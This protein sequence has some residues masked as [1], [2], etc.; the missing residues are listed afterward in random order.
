MQFDIN[1][2]LLEA[3]PP[4]PVPR[5][6]VE[7]RKVVSTPEYLYQRFGRINRE[8]KQREES[9]TDLSNRP[10]IRFAQG[11]Y[12]KFTR[13]RAL[14]REKDILSNSPLKQ[15]VNPPLTAQSVF[16][17]SSDAWDVLEKLI[18]TVDGPQDWSSQ[19]D[20]YLYGIPKRK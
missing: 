2:F 9:I 1:R 20:H 3:N 17:E 12:Q 5:V 11:S 16:P 15:D 4:I 6:S 19:H 7:G 14:Q 13:M 10:D 8:I 18:G